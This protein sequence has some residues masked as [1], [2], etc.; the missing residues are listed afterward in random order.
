MKTENKTN[1]HPINISHIEL[2]TEGNI[3]EEI[4]LFNIFLE[5]AETSLQELDN[6]FINK[7]ELNWKKVAHRMKGS[8]MNL[9][10]DNLSNLCKIAEFGFEE[11]P[12]AKLEMLE[13]IKESFNEV[14]DF[15]KERRS[16]YV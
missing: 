7:D 15:I 16:H 1:T 3:D 2:F 9:G 8:S 12:D 6:A 10:A 11:N 5:Q 14:K 13:E 4:E